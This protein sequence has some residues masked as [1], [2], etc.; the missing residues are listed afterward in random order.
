[1]PNCTQTYC[2]LWCEDNP[3]NE[4]LEC[5][6]ALD[7]PQLRGIPCYYLDTEIGRPDWIAGLLRGEVNRMSFQV[8]TLVK[9]VAVSGGH[10]YPVGTTGVITMIS[11][12]TTCQLRRD[13][14][15]Q[16]GN[17]IAF[18]DLEELDMSR[19]AQAARLKREIDGLETKLATLK[20]THARL[21]E[22]EDDEEEIAANIT[23]ILKLAGDAD[24]TK[25][26]IH[27]LLKGM[28]IK[29]KFN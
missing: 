9:V 24:A 8:G 5:C 28:N 4:G 13:D 21:T 23:K 18:Q 20:K 7:L 15:G 11:N 29:V 19:Q 2:N 25:E 26:T 10:N 3:D 1:M 16:L 22:Y 27:E 12:G 6:S 14:T 17:W